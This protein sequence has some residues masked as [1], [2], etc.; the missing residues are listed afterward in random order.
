MGYF[1]QKCKK[2]KNVITDFISEI[3]RVEKQVYFEKLAR[4]DQH[5]LRGFMVKNAQIIPNVSNFFTKRN[6]S[7]GI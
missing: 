6:P 2:K 7:R 5:G 4:V 1:C 3:K